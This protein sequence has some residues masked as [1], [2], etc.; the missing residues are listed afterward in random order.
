MRLAFSYKGLP[1]YIVMPSANS[2]NWGE[3]VVQV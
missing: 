3:N 2:L 1:S